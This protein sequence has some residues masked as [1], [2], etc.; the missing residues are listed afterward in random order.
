[1]EVQTAQALCSKNNTEG[2]GHAFSPGYASGS[3]PG[4]G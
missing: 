4:S 2:L 1:M 3:N